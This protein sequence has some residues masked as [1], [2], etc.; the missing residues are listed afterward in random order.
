[1]I[2]KK[3]IAVH[4][5]R[6]LSVTIFGL[7][8]AGSLILGPFIIHTP[9]TALVV[10]A[11]AGFGYASYTA[12]TMAFPAEVVPGNATASVWG[13]ASVGAGLGGAVFQSLSG[14]TVKNLSESHSYSMAYN[15]VFIGYGVLA[16]AGVCIVLFFMG[17][18][19]K[20]QRLHAL[21]K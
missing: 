2:I 21:V 5:A 18:L 3:G 19:V 13:L 7:L 11:I 17:P 4:K 16:L 6:K 1:M 14:I 12:N 9:A 8:T 20:D 10:L 15:S